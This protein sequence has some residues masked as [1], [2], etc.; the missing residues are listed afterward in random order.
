MKEFLLIGEFMLNIATRKKN[1][2]IA[3]GEYA[4]TLCNTD[5][6]QNHGLCKALYQ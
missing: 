1:D 5:E 4:V 3:N 2:R 6:D